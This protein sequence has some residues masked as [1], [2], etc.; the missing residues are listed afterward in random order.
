MPFDNELT[1]PQ[2]VNLFSIVF[3]LKLDLSPNPFM[4]PKYDLTNDDH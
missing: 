1:L 3:F 4:M 2:S